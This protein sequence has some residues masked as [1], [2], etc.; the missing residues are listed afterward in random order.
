MH[1]SHSA[2]YLIERIFVGT[3]ADRKKSRKERVK[4]H[5]IC[6]LTKLSSF[7]PLRLLQIQI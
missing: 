2:K 5:T 6:V 4:R 1:L 7:I 3:V